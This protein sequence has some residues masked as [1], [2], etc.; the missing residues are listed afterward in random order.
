M[1]G[2]PDT[3]L[4]KKIQDSATIAK[5][6]DALEA[7]V[8]EL[9]NAY[10]Q[11]F[12]GIERK[13]PTLEH[14]DLKKKILKLKG[15]FVRQTA[16]KFRINA[17]QQKFISYERLWART[18]QE[19]E[20]GTYRRDLAK[21]RLHN[22]EKQKEKDGKAKAEGAAK[23]AA[24]SLEAA[25][26]EDVDFDADVEVTAPPPPAKPPSS[27]SVAPARPAVA[28]TASGAFPAVTPA[29]SVPL[30]AKPPSGTSPGARPP[31]GSFSA[32]KPA[33]GSFP[34]AKPAAP[35]APA[36]PPSGSSPA[37]LRPATASA[38]NLSDTKLKAVYDAYVTAKK[39]C[40]E[41]TSKLSYE[42]VAANLRQQ[43]P[44]LIKKSGAKGVE[45]KILIKDGKAVLRAIPK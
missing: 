5:E 42:S 30:A 23:A 7:E 40:R 33:S 44:E 19:M 3:G 11:F 35:G 22:K 43:V 38:D 25:L 12:L 9:R 45:F 18:L 34:A 41:D 36:R 17:L 32:V 15:A 8:A 28:R 6:A 27:P 39:R 1:A 26:S 13:P 14:K 37:A 24:G 10:E 29:G 4:N 20:D 21:A 2:L 16:L 31:T